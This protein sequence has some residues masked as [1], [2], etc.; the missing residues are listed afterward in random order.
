MRSKSHAIYR[1]L[2]RLYPKSF[3]EQYSEQM[4]Q[5]LEDILDN[6]QGAR[7]RF[8]VWA[9]VFGELPSTVLGEHINNV[10]ERGIMTKFS[11][12]QIIIVSTAV[13]VIIVGIVW[14]VLAQKNSY[15][16]TTLSNVQS[17]TISSACLRKEDNPALQVPGEDGTFIANAVSLS[18]IDVPAGTNFDVFVNSYSGTDATG[19]AIY[20]GKYGSYNFTA[21][22]DTANSNDA[23]TAGWK[24]TKFEACN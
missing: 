16:P 24:V 2:L 13:L 5:T 23:Y 11:K 15:M 8:K 6:E 12:R 18:I 20:N 21:T 9:R 22:H 17:N 19:T 14:Y 4:L 10:K 7:R 3:R 1:A